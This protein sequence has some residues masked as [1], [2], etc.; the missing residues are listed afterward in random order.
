MYV[1]SERDPPPKE[2]E[3][4]GTVNVETSG[5]VSTFPF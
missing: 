5:E 2:G 3:I 4:K 1:V